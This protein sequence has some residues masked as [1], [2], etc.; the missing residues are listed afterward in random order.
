[1]NDVEQVTQPLDTAA[2]ER[3]IASPEVQRLMCELAA[4]GLGVFVPHMHVTEERMVQLPP[5]TVQ[6]EADLHVSFVDEKDPKALAALPVAW[7]W[8]GEARVVGRCRQGHTGGD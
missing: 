6:F 8:D 1:M 7:F 4:H 2:A 3:A 5:G